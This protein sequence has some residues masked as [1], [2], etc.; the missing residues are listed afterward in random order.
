MG[1]YD[2][3]AKPYKRVDYSH[4]KVSL[5]KIAHDNQLLVNH[6]TTISK[7]VS[8]TAAQPAATAGGKGRLTMTKGM[9]GVQPLP[10]AFIAASPAAVFLYSLP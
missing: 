6:L 4:S 9:A 2:L 10:R 1:W 3:Q 5:T 7:A 8:S